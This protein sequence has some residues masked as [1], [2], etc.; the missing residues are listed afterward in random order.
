MA[1]VSDIIRPHRQLS[2]TPPSEAPAS[3]RRYEFADDSTVLYPKGRDG[4]SMR[5]VLI[6]RSVTIHYPGSAK[7]TVY[8]VC[9]NAGRW[10][11]KVQQSL[12]PEPIRLS[13]DRFLASAR[14]MGVSQELIARLVSNQT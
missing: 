12:K 2:T 13:R 1:Q 5:V 6:R 3:Q 11:Y 7:P 10:S 4:K 8:S 9:R 14:N